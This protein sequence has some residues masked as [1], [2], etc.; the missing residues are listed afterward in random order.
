MALLTGKFVNK[1]KPHVEAKPVPAQKKE[2]PVVL[3][4]ESAP[5]DRRSKIAGNKKSSFLD[6]LFEEDSK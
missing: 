2:T 5:V 3:Q 1:A 6:A 4:P